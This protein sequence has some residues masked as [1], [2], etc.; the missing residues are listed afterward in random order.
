ME[1]IYIY[2]EHIKGDFLHTNETV[3]YQ[4]QNKHE[5]FFY[6]LKIYW[7]LKYK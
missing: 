6:L 4:V 5:Y 1:N 7:Q 2:N 3:E